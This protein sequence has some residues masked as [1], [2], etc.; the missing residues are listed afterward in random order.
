VIRRPERFG[1]R[2]A[3][4]GTGQGSGALRDGGESWDLTRL[5]RGT[6]DDWAENDPD[7]AAMINWSGGPL[8]FADTFSQVWSLGYAHGTLHAGTKP[9]SL[10]ASR[11]GGLSWKGSTD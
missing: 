5:T 8:P 11:D 6:M 7:F 9:A 2:A 3:A 10:L 4:T 1:L